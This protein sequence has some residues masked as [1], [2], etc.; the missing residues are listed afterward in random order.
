MLGGL[1]VR[2]RAAVC[3]LI[4][5]WSERHPDFLTGSALCLAR[6]NCHRGTWRAW[7]QIICVRSQFAKV[8]P[9]LGAYSGAGCQDGGVQGSSFIG[10]KD[11]TRRWACISGEAAGGIKREA[12][13]ERSLSDRKK[14]PV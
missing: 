7:L 2:G 10:W 9:G 4:S 5:L 12:V 14:Q 6:E 3:P 1:W 13:W 11:W 8:L